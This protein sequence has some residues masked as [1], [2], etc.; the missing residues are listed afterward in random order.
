MLNY[1]VHCTKC[2]SESVVMYNAICRWDKDNQKWEYAVN[3]DTMY[4]C[5]DCHNDSTE[6]EE[7]E[8]NYKEVPRYSMPSVHSNLVTVMNYIVESEMEGRVDEEDSYYPT[9]RALEDLLEKI[10][11]EQE[12]I[13]A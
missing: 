3:Y 7:R 13:N 8:I 10:N 6:V 2:G 1:S 5:P 11:D 12:S 4:Q 9:Y